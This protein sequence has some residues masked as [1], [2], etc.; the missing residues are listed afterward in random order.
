LVRVLPQ[1]HAT[2][3]VEKSSDF[4]V[5]VLDG[6]GRADVP[7]QLE[8]DVGV[9]GQDESIKGFGA[10]GDCGGIS[11]FAASAAVENQ[12]EKCQGSEFDK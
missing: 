12:G 5:S 11:A 9:Q 1:L 4:D 6:S 3:R 8:S 10:R 7:N 2:E